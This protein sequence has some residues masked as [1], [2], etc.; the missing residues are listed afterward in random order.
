[1]PNATATDDVRQQKIRSLESEI[2]RLTDENDR[3]RRQDRPRFSVPRYFSSI[4]SWLTRKWWGSNLVACS[5]KFANR[6]DAWGK[7]DATPPVKE[8]IEFATSAVVR[9]TRI[10]IFRG[11]FA[12]IVGMGAVVLAIGQ[13]LILDSQTAIIE[14][15]K[16]VSAT[17]KYVYFLREEE[18]ARRLLGIAFDH[19]YPMRELNLDVNST[20][21]IEVLR[22]S[23]RK[24]I[25]NK[26]SVEAIV[27]K[28][29]LSLYPVKNPIEDGQSALTELE[30]GGISRAKVH[31]KDL[32]RWMEKGEKKCEKRMSLM[33]RL[34]VEMEKH[35]GVVIEQDESEG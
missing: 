9:F 7:G 18:T 28:C 33:T 32:R 35:M 2:A 14:E 20:I 34:R 15:S 11:I 6:L 1:M 26:S 10:G 4:T 29:G 22:D 12:S 30:K 8:G 17:D 24:A 21:S 5:D 23:V 3:L 31:A 25:P 13:I 16:R 27:E 19:W